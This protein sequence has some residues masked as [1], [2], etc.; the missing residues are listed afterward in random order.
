MGWALRFDFEMAMVPVDA[1]S[2]RLESM[3][4]FHSENPAAFCLI[5]LA[6]I[7]QRFPLGAL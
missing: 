2:V 6:E 4:N 1:F 3:P 7:Q 5:F